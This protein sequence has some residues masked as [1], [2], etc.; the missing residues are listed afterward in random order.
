MHGAH[1]HSPSS[2]SDT[3]LR[4]GT[5]PSPQVGDPMLMGVALLT[6]VFGEAM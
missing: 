6:W 3:Y 5:L 1:L 4:I 2:W